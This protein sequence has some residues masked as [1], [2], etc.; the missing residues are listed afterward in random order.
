L[1]S[2]ESLLEIATRIP[3]QSYTNTNSTHNH[4]CAYD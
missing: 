1:A 2:S 3:I 4:E